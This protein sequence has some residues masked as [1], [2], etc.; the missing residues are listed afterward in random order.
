MPGRQC[1]ADFIPPFNEHQSIAL[2]L[3]PVFAQPDEVFYAWV[4]K[5][6]NFHVCCSYSN[7]FQVLLG[8]KWLCALCCD[9]GLHDGILQL[10]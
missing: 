10:R 7:I 4:L 2:A 6:R 3:T 1:H 9:G 5:T 8:E